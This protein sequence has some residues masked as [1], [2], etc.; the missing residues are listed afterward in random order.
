MDPDGA[1]LPRFSTGHSGGGT[2]GGGRWTLAAACALVGWAVAARCVHR[3]VVHGTSMAP[4]L[5]DGDR[6]L[7]LA[8]PFGDPVRP[9][10]GDIVAVPDPRLSDRV[11]VKR[12]ASVD[13]VARTLEVLGDAPD[14]STDSRSFGPVPL[15]SV[16]GRAVH[17]YGPA[18][19]S[20]PVPR[21]TEYH[22]A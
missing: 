11:L 1:T 3:V 6:L 7:V 13:R 21:P 12:V 5:L 9:E 22:R 2:G 8:R 17:R 4:T 15:A 10:V 16:L 20:G 19:R 18:D 14:A